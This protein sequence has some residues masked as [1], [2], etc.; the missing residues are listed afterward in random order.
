MDERSQKIPES[1]YRQLLERVTAI[2]EKNFMDNPSAKNYFEQCGIIDTS[3]FTRYRI[4]FC[5]GGL[6]TILPSK[7][8]LLEELKAI[9]IFSDIG[10]EVFAGCGWVSLDH[11]ST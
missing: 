2:Y 11:H 1:R 8:S 7:G 4:G 9:G 5:D 3:L 10:N 6:N